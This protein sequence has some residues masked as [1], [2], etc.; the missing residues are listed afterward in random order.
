MGLEQPLEQRR[1]ER[2]WRAMGAAGLIRQAR[3]AQSA[4]AGQELVAGFA[5]DPVGS[6]Q[7]RDRDDPAQSV[8]DELLAELH[9][10]HLLP[11]HRTLLEEPETWR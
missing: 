10:D 9:G 3:R 8:M 5:A 6:T 11:R 1:I 4:I 7:L 2:S